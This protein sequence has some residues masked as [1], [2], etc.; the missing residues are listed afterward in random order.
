MKIFFCLFTLI[1][2]FY[3]CSE[4]EIN[5]LDYSSVPQIE[6]VNYEIKEI[7][8]FY[9]DSLIVSIKI[10]DRE[11]DVGSASYVNDKPRHLFEYIIDSE[12]NLVT[13]NA[14]KVVP[15]LYRLIPIDF[16]DEIDTVFFSNSTDVIPKKYSCFDFEI[17]HKTLAINDS[18]VMVTDTLFIRRNEDYFNFFLK[19]D[20]LDSNS[21]Y[22]DSY[23]DCR[24]PW[25]GRSPIME[26]GNYGKTLKY[27]GS[28]FAYQRLNDHETI[29]T[30]GIL[31]GFRLLYRGQTI[32]I[33]C[34]IKD[35]ALNKSNEIQSEYIKMM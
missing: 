12:D 7:E 19:I 15:P 10:S 32:K 5:P 14:K 18:L 11:M 29:L 4:N 2:F 17:L 31:S 24:P 30:Y 9:F 25:S 33:S 28:P 27:P 21:G 3:A 8:G 23:Y 22:F 13:Y 1:F 34:Y 26:A 35:N 6:F 16:N 20:T